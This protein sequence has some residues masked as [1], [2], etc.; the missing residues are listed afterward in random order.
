M[1]ERSHA[2]GRP[3]LPAGPMT[4]RLF[5]PETPEREI[6]E[7]ADAERR[8]GIVEESL[9]ARLPEPDPSADLAARI[10]ALVARD[11]GAV[12]GAGP[13]GSVNGVGA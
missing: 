3:R 4:F 6:D 8:A 9:R 1:W 11:P 12:I 5:G 10:V 7:A 13:A 2:S